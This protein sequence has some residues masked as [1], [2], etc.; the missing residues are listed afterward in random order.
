MKESQYPLDRRLMGLRAGLDITAKRQILPCW[1]L[2]P[3]HAA[4]NITSKLMT[5][6]SSKTYFI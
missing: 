5:Y 2:N 1:E 4:C 3:G 6:P